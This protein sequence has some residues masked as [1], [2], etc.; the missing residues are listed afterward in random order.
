MRHE[1]RILREIEHWAF[2]HPHPNATVL[3]FGGGYHS[4]NQIVHEI[5]SRS[6]LGKELM[7]MFKDAAERY[8]LS[9]VLD[10]LANESITAP[11]SR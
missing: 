1:Q 8:S 7:E 3:I 4:P 11:M 2:Q 9:D 10:S 6:R 5:R